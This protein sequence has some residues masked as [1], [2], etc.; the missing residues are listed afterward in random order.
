[1]IRKKMKFPLISFSQFKY[2]HNRW[3]KVWL[4]IS[5]ENNKNYTIISFCLL[6]LFVSYKFL[7]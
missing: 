5:Y 4:V 2:I 6:I 7:K 1:M 3:S